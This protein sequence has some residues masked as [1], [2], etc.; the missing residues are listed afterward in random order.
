MTEVVGEAPE[1]EV[2]PDFSA[3]PAATAAPTAET[4]ES[5]TDTSSEAEALFDPATAKVDEVLAYAANVD[6]AERARILEAEKAGKA[7][8]SLIAKLEA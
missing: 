8:K 4:A 1:N 6:E 2:T 3:Q 5:K 7:R